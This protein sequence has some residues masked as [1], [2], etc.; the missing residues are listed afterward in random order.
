MSEGQGEEGEG[1]G[2]RGGREGCG[3]VRKHIN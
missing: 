2:E 1:S 3:R